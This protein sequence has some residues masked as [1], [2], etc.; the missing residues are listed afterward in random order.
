[1]V[2]DIGTH[3]S[4][5][6][7]AGEDTPKADVPTAIGVGPAKEVSMETDSGP[8]TQLERKYYIDSTYITVPREGEEINT[9][10][11][12]GL[13]EDWDLYQRLIDHLYR[14]HLKTTP[15]EHPVLMSEP[16][17]NVKSKREKVTELMFETYNVPAF[18][19]CKSAVLS[20]F[21]NGRGTALVVDSGAGQTSAVPVHDGYC[22]TGATVRTPL[23]G[24]FIT[25][26]CGHF[27]S[28]LGCQVVPPYMIATKEAVKERAEPVWTRRKNLP[29]VTDSYHIYMTNEILRDFA[30]SVAQVSTTSL[31]DEMEHSTSI[32]STSYEFP[33]GYN[34]NATVEKF[35]LT[36]GLFNAGSANIKGV[37]GGDLLSL[38]NVV[39]NSASQCDVDVRPTLYSNVVVVGGN[40]LLPGFP[41]R[42]NRELSQKTPHSVRVKLV[43]NTSAIERRFSPWIGGSILAS[44]GTFQQMWISKQ[45]Y[46][47]NGKRIV[48]KKCP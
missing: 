9:P 1:M 17:W 46:E 21:A 39:I 12:D 33:N 42:L 6:G 24:N 45:E 3:S 28:E 40:S 16:P 34:L 15:T 44:L 37:S 4:R 27:M 10:L 14:R 11:R 41:E 8:V 47:E 7:Y 48:D 30:M 5:A 43:Q 19:L 22:L 13:V 20:A 29:N 32:P 18:F 38:P 31:Q 36:E 26:Q 25:A 2:F 35:K 23:A